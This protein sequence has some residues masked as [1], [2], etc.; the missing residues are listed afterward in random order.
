MNG[1]KAAPTSRRSGRRGWFVFLAV[2]SFI[3]AII[4][5]IPQ[6]YYVLFWAASGRHRAEYKSARRS[7]VLVH[8]ERG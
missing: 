3:L 8:L 2:Y 5:A 4:T 1:E 6:L 7:L